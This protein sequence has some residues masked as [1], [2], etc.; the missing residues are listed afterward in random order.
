MMMDWSNDDSSPSPRKLGY[1]PRNE[2]RMDDC[3]SNMDRMISAPLQPS[4]QAVAFGRKRKEAVHIEQ[5]LK[6]FRRPLTVF[7]SKSSTATIE[8]VR[9]RLNRSISHGLQGITFHEDYVTTS[10]EIHVRDILSAEE[11]GST[12]GAVGTVVVQNDQRCGSSSSQRNDRNQ[13]CRRLLRGCDVRVALGL[14]PSSEDHFRANLW[15]KGWRGCVQGHGVRPMA[16]NGGKIRDGC[17]VNIVGAEVSYSIISNEL[18][19]KCTVVNSSGAKNW[20]INNK[21][22]R[23]YCDMITA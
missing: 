9:A 4:P 21:G 1:F 13:T 19:I 11:Y 3:Y 16:S 12:F 23:G 10:Q 15:R 20:E 18:Q 8:G 7:A 6:R 22:G 14:S 2:I 17:K 5:P